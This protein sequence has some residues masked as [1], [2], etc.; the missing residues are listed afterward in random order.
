MSSRHL[1]TLHIHWGLLLFTLF[2][3]FAVFD[4]NHKLHFHITIN[5]S[6]AFFKRKKTKRTIQPVNCILLDIKSCR[7]DSILNAS[8]ND[9]NISV[10]TLN[11]LFVLIFNFK[12]RWNKDRKK[13]TRGYM[14]QF[15]ACCLGPIN[16][17]PQSSLDTNGGDFCLS[18]QN[19]RT[20][21]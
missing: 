9:L 14:F 15:K 11:Y 21:N 2:I 6:C 16:G 18:I 19:A 13:L 8:Q 3:A 17:I 7:N 12:S 20:F 10:K 4:F 5:S 1:T